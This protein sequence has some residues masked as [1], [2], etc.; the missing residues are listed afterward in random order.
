M[1]IIPIARQSASLSSNTN[2]TIASNVNFGLIHSV[3]EG[4][5][6]EITFNQKGFSMFGFGYFPTLETTNNNTYNKFKQLSCLFVFPSIT[7]LHYANI[8]V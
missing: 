6:L 1:F 4:K 5:I 7:T 2:A 3:C 8:M